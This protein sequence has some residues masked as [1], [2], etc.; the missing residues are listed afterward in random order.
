[1][2]S[3]G[4]TTIFTSSVHISKTVIVLVDNMNSTENMFFSEMTT[5]VLQGEPEEEMKHA[6]WA[7]LGGDI[8]NAIDPIITIV[9]EYM[10][11]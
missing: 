3:K 10:T 6:Y 7:K 1:M 9:G 11:S 8:F 5:T 4:K 2:A